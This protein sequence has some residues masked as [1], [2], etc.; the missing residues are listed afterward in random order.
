[1]YNIQRGDVVRRWHQIPLIRTH[2]F[3]DKRTDILFTYKMQQWSSCTETVA[4][5]N[6]THIF[7]Q[8]HLQTTQK[9]E[10]LSINMPTARDCC[11]IDP[12]LPSFNGDATE[13]EVLLASFSSPL[14]HST[15][16]RNI[17]AP[18]LADGCPMRASHTT[19]SGSLQ[20][21]LART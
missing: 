19:P 21:Y 18:S 9:S 2:T 10:E 14:S 5:A 17:D 4:V 1:M 11:D 12:L 3:T 8:L 15:P 20:L 7:I 13:S 6:T 16:S